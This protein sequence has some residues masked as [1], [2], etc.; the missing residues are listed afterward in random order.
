[1]TSAVKV[2]ARGGAIEVGVR[3]A[4]NRSVV[5]F[6]R[7]SGPGSRREEP[8]AHAEPAWRKTQPSDRAGIGFALAR[9]MVDAHG[10]QIWTVS[11]PNVGS[12]VC[13]SLTPGN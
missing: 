7:D 9:G 13:F 1:M 6:V 8:P 4:E 12:T 11:E 5:F 10:G 2:T 3:S